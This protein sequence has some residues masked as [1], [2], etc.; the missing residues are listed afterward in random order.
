M[1]GS[2]KDTLHFPKQRIYVSHVIL[3]IGTHDFF[4]RIIQ[5]VFILEIDCCLWGKNW[6]GRQNLAKN[7]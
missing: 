7:Y 2:S 6:I 4:Y 5:F 1:V 3:T